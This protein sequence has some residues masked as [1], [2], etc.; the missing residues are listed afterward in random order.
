MR[1]KR[2]IEGLLAI[3]IFM[4]V[5]AVGV[6][7]F[8]QNF[9]GETAKNAALD[10]RC[11][12]GF[13]QQNNEIDCTTQ[14]VALKGEEKS[15]KKAILN[16]LHD[17]Y[18]TIGEFQYDPFPD[19]QIKNICLVFAKVSF[20]DA[21]V[22]IQDLDLALLESQHG[23]TVDYE[24]YTNNVA[25][26]SVKKAF[27][28]TRDAYQTKE[29]YAIVFIQSQA[30]NFQ[31]YFHE[32]DI[33]IIPEKMLQEGILFL[34]PGDTVQGNALQ[35]SGIGFGGGAFGV[36]YAQ[37]QAVFFIPLPFAEKLNCVEMRGAFRPIA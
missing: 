30:R 19:S 22:S 9:L 31:E 15:I 12:A 16:L 3:A 1:G 5:F 21:P 18:R 25:T 20:S 26:E 28:A 4:L 32:V 29:D 11:Q 8:M 7:I 37:S 13:L 36:V 6:I 27:Q 14:P 34:I 17:T 2:G 35:S 24:A 10:I 33:E 23:G